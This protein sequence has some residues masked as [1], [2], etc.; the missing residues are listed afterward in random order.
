M[1][2]V[3]IHK[4]L[5]SSNSLFYVDSSM[6]VLS[7]SSLCCVGSSITVFVQK[8][9]L[10]WFNNNCVIIQS[11]C[12][13]DSTI[14]VIVQVSA[15]LIHHNC[16][17]IQQSV[18]LCWFI[19]NCVIIQ[20]YVL[21]W[22]ISNC[23]IIRN[24]VLSRFNIEFQTNSM[25]DTAGLLKWNVW[26]RK[27]QIC[28]VSVNMTQWIL[29]SGLHPACCNSLTMNKEEE[30]KEDVGY[31]LICKHSFIMTS[32]KFCKLSS[33]FITVRCQLTDIFFS[34]FHLWTRTLWS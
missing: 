20:K 17:I 19:N 29:F 12:C 25:N 33:Y 23:V 31:F 1:C 30:E 34:L 18:L 22:F 15:V 3:L 24:S 4:W 8:Y 7:S 28:Q 10:C 14:T 32:T 5:L 16:V 11:V 2:V 9:V 13:V 26:G 21:C 27:A 6:T